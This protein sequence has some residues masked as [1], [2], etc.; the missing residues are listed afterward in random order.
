MAG[1]AGKTR[2]TQKTA[3]E[4]VRTS[5]RKHPAPAQAGHPVLLQRALSDPVRSG[6]DGV[7]AL[8]QAAGNRA[9]SHLIQ[10]KLAVGPAHD[11]YEQE[12][13]RVAD[14]VLSMPADGL[15][16]TNDGGVQRQPEEEE[17]QTKPLAATISRLV[18]RQP[19]EEEIQSRSLAP[20]QRQPEEEEIQTKSLAPLQRQ[21]E[22]EEIQTK[23]LALLQRQPEEEEI[24][25]KPVEYRGA[26]VQRQAEEEEIQTKSPAV[27][28]RHG[29]G[30]FEAGP[31]IER[32]LAGN[33]GGG[34]PLS[35]GLRAYMEPRFGTD[36][37]DVR[38]HTGGD[39]VQ[40]S[41]ELDAQSFTHGHD[42]YF[43]ESRYDPSS[44]SGKRLLA[45]ELTH[46]VQQTGHHPRTRLATKSLAS[47]DS[48][49][50]Q[51]V[52]GLTLPSLPRPHLP[53]LP[54]PN[55]PK[56]TLADVKKV[57]GRVGR[58]ALTV[59][60]PTSALQDTT[61]RT[62][63]GK[64]ALHAGKAGL[65]ILEGVAKLLLGPLTYLRLFHAKQREGLLED[66]W[67][68]DYGHGPL[69]VPAKLLNTVTKVIEEVGM[70]S[71]WGSLL[72]GII[73]IALGA[74]TFGAGVG[75]AAAA[76]TIL[77]FIALACAG[78][79]FIAKSIL[80]VGN[81]VRLAKYGGGADTKKQIFK[82]IM[83]ILN[84]SVGILTGGLGASNINL[85][86]MAGTSQAS[87][88]GST[89]VGAGTQAVV[90]ASYEGLQTKR[91]Q[92]NGTDVPEQSQAGGGPSAEDLQAVA[93]LGTLAADIGSVGREQQQVTRK[94]KQN[95]ADASAAVDETLPKAQDK[96][97]AVLGLGS[98][99]EEGNRQIGEVD[100]KSEVMDRDQDLPPEA[101]QKVAVTATRA[102]EAAARDPKD[103][104]PEEVQK[105]TA[106]VQG[107][108]P[109]EKKSLARRAGGAIKKF[110][111]G[112]MGRLTSAK[113]LIQ[114]ITAQIKNKLV[115]LVLKATGADE[116]AHQF[117]A[118]L[119]EAKQ[120]SPQE[121]LVLDEK[122]TDIA[123]MTGAADQVAEVTKG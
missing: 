55:L 105:I 41:R 22:E 66:T 6:P 17:V 107:M 123:D 60:A 33:N 56:P 120:N 57:G 3:Q 76:A 111:G 15:L 109:V 64:V 47:A 119:Q 122:A 39:A 75:P 103:V 121:R 43:G 25:T 61:A 50:V 83:G 5:A 12:A 78:W 112:L 49:T 74:A 38:V 96:L 80:S 8:Q 71:A 29:G 45:H 92:R 27:V 36:L 63:G 79:V 82:D 89:G 104:K 40:M 44:S 102:E 59:V 65:G 117:L 26:L 97:G 18:Q 58:G 95:A 86:G 98:Q 30:S 90:D 88:W 37:G 94:Q 73:G 42:I 118:G 31:D 69:E 93:E 1:K 2:T 87:L 108:T 9:V 99:V 115:G 72:A 20:L 24:Q 52:K 7:L 116:P 32:R 85:A 23:S 110:F 106:E 35:A 114:R 4:V 100:A 19:E 113:K 28:R 14:Q 53:N 91:I 68:A 48:A 67:K 81:I 46:V 10:T 77:G 34:R 51:R 11:S 101:L 70:V 84:A 62:T 21:P 16:S 13:D 54:K